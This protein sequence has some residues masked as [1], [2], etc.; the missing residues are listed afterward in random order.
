VSAVALSIVVVSRGRPD[1]LMRCLAGLAQQ[2]HAPF[3]VIVVA[4]PAGVARARQW[5]QA[6]HV[7]IVPFDEAN[8]SAARNAGI[9]QAAGEAVAFIDDD[10][11]PEP[12]WAARMAA[13]FADDGV[14]AAG[15]FV[16][17]RNG[18]SWQWRAQS[19][20][21]AGRTA[22]LEIGENPLVLTPT[23]GRAIKTEGTNMA[24][25]RSVL[26]ALGGFDPGFRYFLDETDLNLR[27]AA[28]GAATAILPGAVVH[29]GF[30]AS[31]LRRA[32]RVPRDLREI[33]ASWAVF[34][35]RHCPEG[36]RAAVWQGVRA[37]ERRRGLRHM[38]AGRLEPRDVRRL[39]AGLDAGHA[40]GRERP[41][42]AAAPLGPAETAFLP[43]PSDPAR[44][45]L[46]LSGRSWQARRL[47]EEARAVVE[48]GRIVSLC[49][50]SPTTLYHREQF[51]ADGFWEQRGGQFGRSLRSD[52]VF[53]A[54]TMAA[55]VGRERDRLK[56]W[57]EGG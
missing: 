53:R 5:P 14:S 33:G 21:G 22:P 56:P 20:D 25:R 41:E 13:A 54:W 12:T 3:E 52:P 45:V 42:F 11:V 18:I 29:H 31:A 27:L 43:F 30:A 24:F 1:G 26:A 49:L 6:A 35:R 23:G 9:M 36:E 47:R 15:G 39:M 48:A 57:R 40:E 28:T 7:K 17:G 8:I 50:L 37:A 4:D 46:W 32:D 34:L 55:R 16:L 51:R 44:E 19:V 38:V 2:R 10:A